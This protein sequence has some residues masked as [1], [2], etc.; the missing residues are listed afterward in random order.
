[1]SLALGLALPSSTGAQSA[2]AFSGRYRFVLTVSPSCPPTMQVGPLSVLMD[3]AES[4]VDSVTEVS[5][6]SASP[7]EVPENGRFELLRQGSYLHGAFGSHTQYL[8]LDTTGIYRVWLQIMT[9]GTA[10]TATGGRVRA[11]GTAFGEVELSLASD[12]TGAP[13]R[14]DGNCGLTTTGHS[15]S[16]EPA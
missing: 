3:V 12:P 11:A 14:P 7:N 2:P 8:G 1:M 4:T 15:W 6:Q 10:G 13:L 16:L 9:D 5:G